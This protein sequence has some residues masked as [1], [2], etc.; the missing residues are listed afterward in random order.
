MIIIYVIIL[1]EHLPITSACI[2]EPEAEPASPDP[3]PPDT[4]LDSW[5]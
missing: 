3:W 1:V 5:F 4:S 2:A